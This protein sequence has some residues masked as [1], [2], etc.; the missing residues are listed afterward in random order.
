MKSVLRTTAT[1]IRARA[2]TPSLSGIQ[3]RAVPLRRD[4]VIRTFCASAVELLQSAA[5]ALKY[6]EEQQ[7]SD[8]HS[9]AISSFSTAISKLNAS[10][11]SQTPGTPEYNMLQQSLVNRAV[12]SSALSDWDAA[13]KDFS[14][15]L[16]QDESN[17]SLLRN[18]AN[19]YL[20]VDRLDEALVD[21]RKAAELE[22]K[23]VDNWIMLGSVR[24]LGGDLDGAIDCYANAVEYAT[25]DHTRTEAHFLRAVMRVQKY[26]SIFD[27]TQTQQTPDL[28]DAA[29]TDPE[30]QRQLQLALDD[31]N[32]AVDSGMADPRMLVLR[33]GTH[34]ALRYFEAAL[35]DFD[36]AIKMAPDDWSMYHGRAHAYMHM[37]RYQDAVQDFSTAL[38]K[39]AEIRGKPDIYYNR[40]H[41]HLQLENYKSAFADL[42]QATS[43][44]EPRLGAWIL[45]AKCAVELDKPKEGVA[46][47]DHVLKVRPD[48]YRAKAFR[49]LAKHQDGAHAEASKDLLEALQGGAIWNA[50]AIG[51]VHALSNAVFGEGKTE[52]GLALVDGVVA[53]YDADDA[54]KVHGVLSKAV[55]EAMGIPVDSLQQ[56]PASGGAQTGTDNVVLAELPTP[57]I[58]ELLLSSGSIRMNLQRFEEAEKDLR[59]HL[60]HSSSSPDGLY[61]YSALLLQLK[62]YDE[63]LTTLDEALR[64]QPTNPYLLSNKA[65]ALTS[66]R[67]FDEAINT[68][69][70]AVRLAREASGVGAGHDSPVKWLVFNRGMAFLQAGRGA[71]AVTDFEEVRKAESGNVVV[72]QMLAG[73]LELA[74]RGQEALGVYDELMVSDPSNEMLA[75]ARYELQKR[76]DDAA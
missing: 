63:A 10:P 73:A 57:S 67:R 25:A 76:L 3:F 46:A 58:A 51:V 32:V 40:S 27:P 48:M 42:K 23:D 17:V 13:I 68:F 70:D 9:M 28:P 66:L 30:V 16:K 11:R 33:A 7:T 26:S 65:S 47:F 52:Q 14:H 36:Q 61:T 18:R 71:E 19:V 39:D 24:S 60:S 34:M 49:G 15:V 43:L 37:Q 22:P 1:Q 56:R 8:N 75:K 54:D 29:R 2:L 35:A 20:Q 55:A 38:N 72:R 59:A 64:L 74:G 21:A 53:A 69:N 44:G 4:A 31:F 5:D 50:D 12:S 62:R 45:L 41:A 6:G